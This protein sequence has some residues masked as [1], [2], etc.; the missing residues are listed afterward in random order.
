MDT[1]LA[2]TLESLGVHTDYLTDY[3]LSLGKSTQGVTNF[4]NSLQALTDKSKLLST[5]GA[6]NKALQDSLKLSRVYQLQAGLHERMIQLSQMVTNEMNSDYGSLFQEKKYKELL[7]FAKEQQDE[8][9]QVF[10]L[11]LSQ[12]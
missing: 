11:Q 8:Q 2:F 5:A 4:K 3:A 6:P 12:L 1:T 9:L 10:S 7:A